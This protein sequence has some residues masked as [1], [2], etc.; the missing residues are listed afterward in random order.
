[1]SGAH[2]VELA[3]THH[4]PESLSHE[5]LD[6]ATCGRRVVLAVFQHKGEHLFP[7]FR[8]VTVAPLDECVLTFLLNTLE[9]PIHSRAMH[10][11]RIASARLCGGHPLLHTLNN[12]PPGCLTFLAPAQCRYK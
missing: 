11:D 6:L 8:G 1:V 10:G 4:D 12:L 9:Q 2:A 7:K 5:A 3:D